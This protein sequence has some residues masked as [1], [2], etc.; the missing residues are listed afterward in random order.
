MPL[1][2]LIFFALGVLTSS[3]SLPGLAKT[4][5]FLVTLHPLASHVSL[6]ALQVS[7]SLFSFT[8]SS[9]LLTPRPSRKCLAVVL[10]T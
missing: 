1:Y 7:L 4:H 10:S 8:V 9:L 5:S 6:K 3:Y 2:A